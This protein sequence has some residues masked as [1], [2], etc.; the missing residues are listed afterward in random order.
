M[1]NYELY[2]VYPKN[3]IVST[4]PK[5]QALKAVQCNSL[6]TLPKRIALPLQAIFPNDNEIQ[7]S[8]PV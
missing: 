1:N 7:F 3:S 6:L 4:I 5:V 2:F 8:V